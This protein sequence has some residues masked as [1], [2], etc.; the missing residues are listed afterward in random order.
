MARPID[1]S[2]VEAIRPLGGIADYTPFIAAADELVGQLSD[3]CGQEFTEAGLESIEAWLTA[4]MAELADP[5]IVRREEFEEAAKT[6]NVGT[7]G[8]GIMSTGFGTTAN[9][10]SGG[11]LAQVD[12]APAVVQFA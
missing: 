7:L 12:L 9:M 4:H 11:C 3:K 8:R 6:Y 1:S 10:L 5:S 2:A